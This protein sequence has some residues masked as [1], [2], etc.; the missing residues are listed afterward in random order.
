MKIKLFFSF[1]FISPYLFAMQP[2]QWFRNIAPQVQ[3][4][5]KAEDAAAA[6]RE[7]LALAQKFSDPIP[8]PNTR[9]ELIQEVKKLLERGANPNAEYHYAF[10]PGQRSQAIISMAIPQFPEIVELLLKAGA[11]PNSRAGHIE[12]IKNS[13]IFKAIKTNDLTTVTLLLKYGAD[14]DFQDELGQT[15]LLTAVENENHEMIRLLLEAGA[16]PNI[17]STL[18]TSPLINAVK[19]GNIGII[20]LLLQAGANPLAFDRIMRE[21]ALDTAQ[22]E[23]DKAQTEVTQNKYKEIIEMLEHPET[24]KRIGLEKLP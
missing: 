2:M 6:T 24:I 20:K 21:S 3:A 4:E 13:V 16:Y 11:N 14:P 19:A 17:F 8:N 12:V 5:L 15:P 10:L 7:L 18:G 1:V 22:K 9:R 23:L